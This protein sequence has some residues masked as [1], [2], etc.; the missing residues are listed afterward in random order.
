MKKKLLLIGGIA[1][2][3]FSSCDQDITNV[4]NLPGGESSNTPATQKE[5]TFTASM[6]GMNTRAVETTIANLGSFKVS[7][8]DSDGFYTIME[9]V[10]YTSSDNGKTWTTDAGKFYWPASNVYNHN[11]FYA[12]APEAP[13]KEGTI[14]MNSTI[15]TLNDFVPNDAAANQKDF[16]YATAKGNYEDDSDSPVNLVFKHAL[17]EISIKAKNSNADYTVQVTGVQLGNIE[18]KGTFQFPGVRSGDGNRWYI[19]T[20]KS[21]KVDYTTT[22]SNPVTLTSEA[23]SLDATNVPFMLIPQQLTA[24]NDKPSSG[25]FIAARISV[26]KDNQTIYNG[27]SYVAIDTTWEMGKH[28]VYTLDF[29]NGLGKTYGDVDIAV[30]AITASVSVTDWVSKD[31]SVSYGKK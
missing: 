21:Q 29:S 18:S 5:I 2:M 9:N 6:D 25:N 8:L 26:K 10:K 14:K 28:Y 30:K 3:L 31:E 11:Y 17:S 24:N 4:I 7:A 27:W 13:G 12:Y 23:S 15:P 20:E 19:Y 22:W 1:A 16:V